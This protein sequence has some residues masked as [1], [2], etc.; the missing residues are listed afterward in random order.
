MLFRMAAL[1][2]LPMPSS[3]HYTNADRMHGTDGKLDGN[4]ISRTMGQKGCPLRRFSTR[5]APASGRGFLHVDNRQNCLAQFD[6]LKPLQSLEVL[7][8]WN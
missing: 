1:L 8:R 3:S 4:P 2:R 5:P 7:A 6:Y